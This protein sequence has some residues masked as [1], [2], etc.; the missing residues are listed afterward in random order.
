MTPF[1]GLAFLTS[2]IKRTGP[3]VLSFAKK[4]RT[5]GMAAASSRSVASGT[6]AFARAISSRLRATMSSRIVPI[7]GLSMLEVSAAGE[8][9]GHFVFIAG[10][11]HL[12]VAA[13]TS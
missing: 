5:G 3:G 9:H 2:A 11:N 10:G 4:S 13:R 8:D 7:A 12:V 6:A 1:E